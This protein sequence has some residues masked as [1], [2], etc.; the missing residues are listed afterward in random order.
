MAKITFMGAG[1]TIFVK[2]IIGDCLSTPSLKDAHFALYDIDAKRLKESQIMIETLNQNCNKGR[3]K[4]TAHHGV[5][6]RKAALK[7]ADYVI[8]AIQVGGYKPGTVIDFEIPKKY[9]LRQTIADT[10]GIGG[11]FRALRTIPVMNDFAKDMEQVCPDA[12][13]LNYTNPMAMLSGFMQRHTCIKCIGLCHSVQVCAGRLLSNAGF[14][15]RKFKRINW[16]IAG[17]NHMSWLLELKDG[18]KDLYPML[19][20]KLYP[21]I[22]TVLKKGCKAISEDKGSSKFQKNVADDIVRLMYMKELGYYVTESTI[23][24][25]EYAPYWIKN[26]QPDL[27]EKFNIQLDEYPKRC[28]N[29]IERW[30]KTSKDLVKNKGLKHKRTH[31][32]GSRIIEAMET[33]KPFVFGGSVIN[34]GIISNLPG[35]ACVEVKCVAD[36]SGISPTYAGA[37]PEQCA[38]LTRTNINPQLMTIEAAATLKKDAVYQAAFL[39]PHTAAELTLD[40]IRSLC[41]DLIKAHGKML[42]KYK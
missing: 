30:E 40:Q 32:Y 41:D 9:G 22:T 2:N 11:I 7:N 5:K 27:L 35:N 14:D 39:D 1:S 36:R 29:Q 21:M 18:N 20:K 38:A 3:A 24:H 31:E 23:H 12:W 16:K 15:I 25:S 8:N 28:I 42:P 19:R 26:S 6:S 10:I 13:F 17:I 34:N 33:D 4:I 37:L